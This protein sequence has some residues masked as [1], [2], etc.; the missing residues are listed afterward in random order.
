VDYEINDRFEI[1]GGIGAE[2]VSQESLF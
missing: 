2:F 1:Q